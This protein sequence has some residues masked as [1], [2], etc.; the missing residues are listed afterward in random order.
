[1]FTKD[2]SNQNM[3]FSDI[4]T[5]CHHHHSK[6]HNQIF[7]VAPNLHMD[8]SDALGIIYVTKI[9]IV[10]RVLAGWGKNRA[11]SEG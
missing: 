1:M 5:N 8:D 6:G 9:H 2:I 11:F 4:F 7:S 10:N 3:D